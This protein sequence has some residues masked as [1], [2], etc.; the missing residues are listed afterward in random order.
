MR[1]RALWSSDGPATFS[2]TVE[3][4]LRAGV[5]FAQFVMMTPFPGTVDFVRWEK[6]QAENPTFVDGTP[7]TRYWLIPAF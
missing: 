2:A 4:A 1:I 3:L 7:I 6:D 5:T